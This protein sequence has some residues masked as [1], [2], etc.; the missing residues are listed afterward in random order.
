MDIGLKNRLVGAAVLF[1]LGIIFIPMLL[2]GQPEPA[3]QLQDIPPEP[4]SFVQNLQAPNEIDLSKEPLAQSDIKPVIESDIRSQE[5]N[6]NYKQDKVFK[7]KTHLKP[8][9]K[10][11]SVKIQKHTQ[12]GFDKRVW[13]IQ[14]GSFALAKNAHGLIKKLQ[15]LGYQAFEEQIFTKKG[16]VYRV[17]VGPEVNKKQAIKIR[18]DIKSRVNLLGLV[19]SYP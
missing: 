4:E 17:R 2:D 10:V 7:E 11:S 6:K 5:S 13:V 9:K 3:T 16:P 8:V 18:N 15:S 1:S 14:V 12:V 19:V